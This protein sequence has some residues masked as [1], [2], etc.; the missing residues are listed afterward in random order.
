[1]LVTG[2]LSRNRLTVFFRLLLAIPH[3]IWVGLWGIVA[4]LA[5]IA[6]WF[7]VLL[8]GKAPAGLH[9]F[10]TSYVNYVTHVYAYVSV[11]ANRYPGFTGERGYEVDLEFDPPARQNRWTVLFRLILAVPALLLA[12]V[13]VG[14]G[15]G[16]YYSS[17]SGADTS[18]SSTGTNLRVTGLLAAAAVVMWFYSLVRGRAPEGVVR[19]SWYTIHYAAQAYAYAFV[20]TDRYPNSDPAVLGVPRRPPPH[21]IVLRVPTD[22]LERSRITVFF[23]LALAFPHF[24]WLALWSILALIVA[25]LN[26]IATV[27]AGRSPAAFHRFLGAF[28][29]YGAHV[30]AFVSL[31]ANPFP[32]FAG[33]P[34]SYPV[35]VEIAGPERQNRLSTLFRFILVIP[36]FL[37]G[38]GLSAA[39]YVVAFLGW[40]ASLFTGRMPR[41]LRNLGAFS[42]RYSAQVNAY[43]LGL[44]TD[45]YPYGG[46]PA[47]AESV[48]EAPP[49]EGP[50]DWEPPVAPPDAPPSLA[51]PTDPRGV[52]K[53]PPFVN[54]PVE[55][56]PSD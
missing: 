24:V 33:T 41:G 20:L 42:I 49:G 13:M 31:V 51:D 2:D 22:E 16:G 36:A 56:E 34:G 11:A 28:I 18:S 9:R 52:W 54:K 14:G 12:V 32:G 35:D 45:R 21:P 27:F 5:A 30:T 3:F 19:L 43:G 53:D 8:T 39:L 15:G 29:R 50:L 4:V 23:R 26:W 1:M 10:L 6:N 47:D 17:G 40:W 37:I 38:A 55:T 7:A 25:I 46:P 44:L 48:P